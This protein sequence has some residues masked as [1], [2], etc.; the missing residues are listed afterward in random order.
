M[1]V[2]GGSGGRIAPRVR[3]AVTSPDVLRDPHSRLLPSGSGI[4]C[5]AFE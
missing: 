4:L 5:P 1:D 2:G 3:G